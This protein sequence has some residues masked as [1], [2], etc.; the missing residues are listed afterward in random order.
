[1]M[2]DMREVKKFHQL[3]LFENNDFD[4]C[5]GKGESIRFWRDSWGHQQLFSDRFS[6][7]Y[8]LFKEN[9]ITVSSMIANWDK[10]RIN[11]TD[12]WRRGLRG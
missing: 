11:N 4:W 12:F 9:D 1:M 8:S 6:R 2:Q 3:K 10:V 7:L 5:L